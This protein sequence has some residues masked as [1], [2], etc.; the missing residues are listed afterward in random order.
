MPVDLDPL[1][2]VHAALWSLLES[3]A[4][5][6][7][8][9][10]AKNRIKFAGKGVA[11]RKD[12]QLDAD[13]PEVQIR[14]KSVMPALNA[15]S[16]NT[17]VIAQFEVQIATS[18]QGLDASLFPVLWETI[19]ALHKYRTVL[20]P[21]TWAGQ[22]FV[23][24]VQATSGDIGVGRGD[25]DRGMLWWSVLWGCEIEMWFSAVNLLPV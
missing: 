2:Q 4:A 17:K 14:A 20:M 12:E 11:P 24:R 19:R 15:D 6:A 21:L 7:A 3:D 1:T 9:V 16:T 23:R 10:K 13:R 22:T 18:E 5:W 25:A 8:L